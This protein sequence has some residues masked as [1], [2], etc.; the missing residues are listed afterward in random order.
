M[1]PN[2]KPQKNKSLGLNVLVK[3]GSQFTSF[4]KSKKP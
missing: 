1:I 4:S 3:G 2:E